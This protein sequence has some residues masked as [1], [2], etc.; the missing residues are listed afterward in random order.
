MYK[1]CFT[2][3]HQKKKIKKIESYTLICHKKLK[4]KTATKK[5]YYFETFH[6]FAT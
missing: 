4:I 2:I 5:L 1:K 3:N 6:I